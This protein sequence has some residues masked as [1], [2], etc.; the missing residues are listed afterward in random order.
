[1]MRR[2]WVFATRGSNCR[3]PVPCYMRRN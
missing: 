3:R 1:M 2:S